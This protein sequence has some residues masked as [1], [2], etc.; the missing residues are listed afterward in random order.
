MTPE[1][2]LKI[3]GPF[4]KHVDIEASIIEN[5]EDH[6]NWLKQSGWKLAATG[7]ELFLS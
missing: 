3:L 7:E 4:A 5:D 2:A 1:E 6:E